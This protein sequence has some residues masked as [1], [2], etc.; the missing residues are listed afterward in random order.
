MQSGVFWGYVALIE[1]LIRRI[2]DEAGEPL[3]IVGHGAVCSNC[4]GS[5]QLLEAS[6]PIVSDE[7]MSSIYGFFHAPSMIG[8]GPMEGGTDTCFG[9]SGG[10]L[11]VPVDGIDI[12]VGDTSWGVGCGQPDRPAGY[13]E[14]WQGAMR[15]FADANV[16]RPSN[17]RFAATQQL[18]GNAGS[19][20][21]NNTSATS[22]PGETPLHETSVW[23]SWTPSLSGPAT[24]TVSNAGFDPTLR[25]YTGPA[26]SDVALVAGSETA[27]TAARSTADFEVVAGTTYQIAV[28]GFAFGFGPFVL[29]YAVG[30]PPSSVAIGDVVIPEGNAGVRN[31]VFTVSLAEPSDAPVTVPYATANAGAAAGPDYLAR[32]GTVTIAPGATSVTVKVP[33]A[34][35]TADEVDESFIVTLSAVTGVGVADGTGIGTIVDDDPLATSPRALSVGDVSV[36]E[37]DSG[38]RTAAF[39]VS[40]SKPSASTVTVAFAT[41]NST[42][43]KQGDYDKKSGTLSF[44]PGATGATVKVIVNADTASEGDETF[45]VV[46]SSPNGASVADSTGTATIVD[47][48]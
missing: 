18:P 14:V 17:D 32:S 4:F 34:G 31:A 26:L 15:D 42:A 3:T 13:G 27:P 8:A 9:D 39:T 10:P 30:E 41:A 23:Y 6:V 19:V 24:V 1:G 22:E 46:L 40:L 36:H 2:K 5:A 12:Q 7:T 25:V 28:D 20:A 37:G 33:V 45:V 29:G 48:D 11:L 43:S 16:P 47:D 35:D 21:G 44:P 38:P